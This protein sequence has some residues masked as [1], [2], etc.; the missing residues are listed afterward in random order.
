MT[1]ECNFFLFQCETSPTVVQASGRIFRINPV[2]NTC[3]R[4]NRS[5]LQGSMVTFSCNLF[6]LKRH[7]LL[8]MYSV[9]CFTVQKFFLNYFWRLA[10]V[11]PFCKKRITL[12]PSPGIWFVSRFVANALWQQENQ[13]KAACGRRE[14]E[15]ARLPH[16]DGSEIGASLDANLPPSFNI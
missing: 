2:L 3:K 14:E 11:V 8:W 9:L 16:D 15:A 5:D 7:K 4:R 13:H 10:F 6:A 12:N 1:Y